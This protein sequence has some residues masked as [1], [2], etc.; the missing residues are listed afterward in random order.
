[1]GAGE[2]EK[3]LKEID[4][5]RCIEQ[6]RYRDPGKRF[7]IKENEERRE[8]YTHR[9]VETKSEAMQLLDLSFFPAHVSVGYISGTVALLSNSTIVKEPGS[10][11]SALYW[12]SSA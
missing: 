9:N 10:L 1:M 2:K 7:I 6:H 8:V 5:Y 4:R 3:K 11:S 12:S